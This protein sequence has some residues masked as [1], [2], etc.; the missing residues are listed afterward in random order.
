MRLEYSICARYLALKRRSIYKNET[1][2]IK[3]YKGCCMK[4]DV[5]IVAALLLCGCAAVP[6][7]DYRKPEKDLDG[8]LKFTLP[9]STIL[10]KTLPSSDIGA[11]AVPDDEYGDALHFSLMT[12][13][14][15]SLWTSSTL[16]KLE[17]LEGHN[18]VTAVA[19]TGTSNATKLLQA[20]TTAVRLAAPGTSKGWSFQDDIIEPFTDD[21]GHRTA[22]QANRAGPCVLRR[23]PAWRCTITVGEPSAWAVPY[24]EFRARALR[25]EASSVFPAS[26][27][28]KATITLTPPAAPE[29]GTPPLVITVELAD[30]TYV[31]LTRL[32]RGGE[33]QASGVCR[34]EVT[35]DK[36][37]SSVDTDALKEAIALVA[38]LKARNQAK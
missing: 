32:R 5:S 23:N 37:A 10:L 14:R 28:R 36:A 6:H 31:N 38:A 21:Q 27:C 15:W 17:Y 20:A 22:P 7:L 34:Y 26:A 12:D 1:N 29:G 2:I 13:A 35:S 16:T 24:D 19:T 9:Q 8:F 30:P 25:G 4:K 3:P 11:M 18:I 33:L